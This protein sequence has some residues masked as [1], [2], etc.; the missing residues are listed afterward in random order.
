MKYLLTMT[1]SGDIFDANGECVARLCDSSNI[2]D[3]LLGFRAGH[4]PVDGSIIREGDYQAWEAA[5]VARRQAA[6]RA[7]RRPAMARS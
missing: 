1:T 5:T 2:S 6:A 3:F 4:G 7:A